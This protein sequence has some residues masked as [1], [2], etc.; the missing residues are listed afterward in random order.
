MNI[1][2]VKDGF[3]NAKMVVATISFMF[4]SV[5]GGYQVIT[6]YFVT[7]S[8]AQELL[9]NVHHDIDE[10]KKQTKSNQ[11]TLI[12]M[13]MMRIENKMARGEKLTP[14]ET[15]VYEELKIKHMR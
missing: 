15:R 10:L 4:A 8:Y 9:N 12:E 3:K 14:T 1:G 2:I 6:E 5:I 11:K 7:K 13:S